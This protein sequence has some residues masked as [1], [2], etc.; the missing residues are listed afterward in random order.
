MHL[1]VVP[2]E[3]SP[4]VKAIYQR[5]QQ[6]G[7]NPNA[8]SK[9]GDC[10]ATPSWFL[11]DFD[12]GSAYYSLGPYTNLQ[13]VIDQ[14]HGSFN[15][16]S[17]AAGRGY[18][19]ATVLSPLW[20]DPKVCHSGETPLACELRVNKPAFAFVMLGTNDAS[21]P[22]KF[23]AYLQQILNTL[24]QA[25]VVPILATK[26]DNL[27]GNQSINATIATLAYQ[28]GLPLWNF[29]L[30]VQPLPAKGLQKDLSHLTFAPDQFDN[31]IDMRAAWPWRNLTALQVLDTVSRGITQVP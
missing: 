23:E 3:I 28:Q 14:F 16:T 19:A 25:G 15:R 27:E 8:F 29:W 13:L 4:Y 11:G 1:P 2:V 9:I 10:E 20:A 17:L 24:I 5:G 22:G 6:L 31:P 30:A 7:N 26:A 12:L 21:N 18:A